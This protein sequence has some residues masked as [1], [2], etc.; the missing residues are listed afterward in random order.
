MKLRHL[1]VASLLAI[2]S[3]GAQAASLTYDA[4]ASTNPGVLTPQSGPNDYDASMFHPGLPGTTFTDHWTL[5]IT[6]TPAAF[7]ELVFSNFQL[8][9]VLDLSF[10][11]GSG[12]SFTS[13]DDDYYRFDGTLSPGSYNIT[14]S[15]LTSGSWGGSYKI[16]LNAA[17]VPIPPAA[18]LFGSALIGLAG[19]R[20]RK[21]AHEA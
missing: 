1:L 19:L 5:E 21:A 18:L 11:G 3:A 10:T 6:E 2:A 16:E 13:T 17:P 8:T 7:V 14:I 20:R 15:G 9:D 12:V 4:S